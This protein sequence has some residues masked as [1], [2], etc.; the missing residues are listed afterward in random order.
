MKQL[1][2][3]TVIMGIFCTFVVSASAEEPFRDL[4]FDQ[5]CKAAKLEKKVVMI[6][7][8]TTWWEPCKMLDQTTWKDARVR[9]WLN[10]K[11]VPIK[12]NAEKALKLGERY[13][14]T[15]YPT[16]LFLK[17][18]GERIHALIGYREAD[19]FLE[20]AVYALTT[21][22]PLMLAREALNGH[23]TDPMKRMS[24]ADALAKEGRNEEALKEYLW[25][26]DHGDEHSKSFS[27]V[28]AT[29][30][31]GKIASM[32]QPYAPAIRALEQRS[33]AARV[34]VLSAPPKPTIKS[35]GLFGW[36]KLARNDWMEFYW[37]AQEL[38]T[39]NKELGQ[40]K[41]TLKVFDRL[42][43]KGDG[44]D[45]LRKAMFFNVFD[46]LWE[47]R[48][49]DDIVDGI[50]DIQKWIDGQESL[51]RRT[52]ATLSK[53]PESLRRPY[54]YTIVKGSKCYEAL[55]GV[56]QREVAQ[57]AAKRLIK[58]DPSAETYVML[59]EHAIRAGDHAAA[60]SLAKRG[61]KNLPEDDR[62]AVQTA[63]AKADDEPA[64][65]P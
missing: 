41:E 37:A 21:K 59:I 65:A 39:L 17:P 51:F 2:R 25:C 5:A 30:L 35:Q 6:D 48:R 31:V 11:T 12:L 3:L 36:L 61:L 16:I 57:E 52:K 29:S 55:L 49:Y 40:D 26:F 33:E 24:Y 19:A 13:R 10:D 60:R 62:A 8:Y 47:A 46:S 23:K 22:T 64:S 42:L 9:A 38:S 20:E 56:G 32:T 53:Y 50:G 27:G 4:D 14:V 43:K 34:V 18:N 44:F 28:R 54:R 45:Y 7:F 1:S 63:V 58:L 15:A